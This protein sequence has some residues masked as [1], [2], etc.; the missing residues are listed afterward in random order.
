MK[1][2]TLI[3]A[4][5]VAGAA[6]SYAQNVNKPVTVTTNTQNI[7]QENKKNQ[8]DTAVQAD[9]NTYTLKPGKV[10]DGVVKA[11]KA[12]E[13]GVVSGYKA[14]ENGVVNTYKK[15]EDAFVNTFLEKAD[16]TA[17]TPNEKK[18]ETNKTTNK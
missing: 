18:E 12:V 6:T 5:F 11:Y 9:S 4:V 7:M 14:V 2:L 16:S 3:V 17:A 13:N 8:Q 15:V 10:G 1:K